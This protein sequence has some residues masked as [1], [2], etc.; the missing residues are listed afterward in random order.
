M[1]W[2]ASGRAGGERG[3][4]WGGGKGGQDFC[5]LFP[6]TP[7]P[8]FPR[9]MFLISPS[10]HEDSMQTGYIKVECHYFLQLIDM[11]QKSVHISFF[12]E[13]LILTCVRT[14][15]LYVACLTAS[16]A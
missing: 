3:R 1:H 16:I 11:F 14:G 6:T 10:L 5:I 13:G 7:F 2:E 4:A 15:S 12:P 9:N 8:T